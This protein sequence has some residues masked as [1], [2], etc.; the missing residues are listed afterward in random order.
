MESRCSF[1]KK[2]KVT[3]SKYQ[4]T[5][6]RVSHKLWGKGKV[7]IKSYLPELLMYFKL[8]Q[9]TT[10]KWNFRNIWKEN[11]PCASRAWGGPTALQH[12]LCSTGDQTVAAGILPRLRVRTRTRQRTRRN[13]GVGQRT[14]G[15]L[16]KA[17]AW[18][19]NIHL[20]VQPQCPQSCHPAQPLVPTTEVVHSRP[21]IFPAPP[22]SCSAFC[23]RHLHLKSPI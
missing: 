8:T 22:G 20:D 6:R 19:D 12:A 4:Q 13:T 1:R 3:C 23:D 2:P 7:K 10:A 17:H 5:C 16:S 21:C 9:K 11:L 15:V 14:Q 18:E